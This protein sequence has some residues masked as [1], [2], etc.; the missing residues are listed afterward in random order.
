MNRTASDFWRGRAAVVTGGTAGLGLALVRQLAREGASVGIIA[1]GAEALESVAGELRSKGVAV[2]TASSDVCVE[3]EA[4]A[5]IQALALKLGRIDVL[6]NNVGVSSRLPVIEARPADYVESFRVNFLTALHCT[7]AALPWLQANRGSIV[8]IASLAARTAWPFMAPY[9]AGKSA[10]ALWSHQ[11]RL[12]L[13]PAVHVLLV[14]PGPIRRADAGQRYGSQVGH[15]PAA[16]A[17]AGAGVR[18][19]GLDP[20]WLAQKILA[21]VRRRKLELV[22]PAWARLPFAIAQ[23]SPRLGDWILRRFG[24]IRMPSAEKGPISGSAEPRNPAPEPSSAPL[25]SPPPN[26]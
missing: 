10:L 19:S 1:R 4:A 18:L 9:A 17:E 5:A 6:I 24:A 3:S 11:L 14:C 2:A 22:S 8:N 26:R 15:L 23:I 21:G 25:A 13:S 7:L 16:A 20:D 12:E